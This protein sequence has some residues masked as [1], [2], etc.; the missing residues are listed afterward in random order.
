MRLPVAGALACALVFLAPAAPAAARPHAVIA[1]LPPGPGEHRPLLDE[2]AARGMA[3]GVT[4]PTVGGFKVRQVGLDMSQGARIPTRLYSKE[5]GSLRL[6]GGRLEGWDVALRR[7]NKAPGDL[8]PG[9][10]AQTILDAGGSVGWSGLRGRFTIGP[11]VAA[12]EKGRVSPRHPG[13]TLGVVDL[14][15][16]AAGLRELDRLLARRGPDDFVYVVRAPYGRKLQ[17]LP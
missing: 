3:I 10:L 11:I 13:D 12:D 1:F 17:L 5:I 8:V 15:P 2:L 7:A 9:L 16:G 14:A 4:S 6:R